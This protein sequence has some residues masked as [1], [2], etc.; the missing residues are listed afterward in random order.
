M[1][2][3]GRRRFDGADA[4]VNPRNRC[5]GWALLLLGWWASGTLS[6]ATPAA[7]EEPKAEEEHGPIRI[8]REA[9]GLIVLAA[10]AETQKRIGLTVTAAVATTHQRTVK[11]LGRLQTDPAR[12]F[13]LRAPA[14]GVLTAAPDAAW[15]TIGSDLE[16]GTVLG[17]IEPRFTASELVDLHAR[18][19]DAQAELDAI[20]ADV[21]AARASYESKSRLNTEQGLVSDRSME[22]T[23]ARLR[24]GEARLMAARQ[25]VE[26]YDSL[27]DGRPSGTSLFPVKTVVAGSVVE[28]GAQPGETVD[29]GHVLLRTDRF[30]ALIA[31][32]S[33]FVGESPPSLGFEAQFEIV[34]VDGLVLPGRPIGPAFDASPLTGGM[35]LL[36]QIDVPAEHHLRPG[37]AV[38]AHIPTPGP[39]RSGVEIPRAAVLRLGGRT[40]AYVK[41]GEER[42]ERRDVVLAS[43]TRDGWFATAGVSPGENIVVGGASL[44]LSE[45]LKAQIESEA[46]AGE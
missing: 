28:V 23:R 45:E 30:D 19:S 25:K 41:A 1:S 17:H 22:E 44:L 20:N 27:V 8:T 5:L 6:I 11:A 43:P 29:A 46:E 33:L 2:P 14:P 12:S 18:R 21:E 15:P 34:G 39:T 37:V 7:A 13:T 4:T 16:A 26:L 10:D 32:V 35:A 40:W 24:S 9:D 36:F 42:F 38:T 3:T 31:H